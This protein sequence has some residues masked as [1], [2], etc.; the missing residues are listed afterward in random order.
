MNPFNFFHSIPT[1][2]PN[3]QKETLLNFTSPLSCLAS[4]LPTV[5]H[6]QCKKNGEIPSSAW[7]FGILLCS[8]SLLDFFLVETGA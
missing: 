3:C 5:S 4:R 6:D 2:A 1:N 7:L 8:L